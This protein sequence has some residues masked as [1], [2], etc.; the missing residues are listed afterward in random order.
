MREV[1]LEELLTAGSHFGHQVTRSN[2]KARE[3]I[4]EARDNIHI[5]DLAITKEWLEEAGAYVLALSKNPG[6]TMV[7]VGTKRQAAP[8][9]V[10]QVKKAKEV[11]KD[12]TQKES[13]MYVTN[14]WIGGLLTNF[15]EVSKNLKK[16]KDIEGI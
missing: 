16:L 3:F 10:E 9:V 7:V 5:I 6:T 12:E 14:R 2:P 1:S 8:I 13:I 15:S 4:F 11:I